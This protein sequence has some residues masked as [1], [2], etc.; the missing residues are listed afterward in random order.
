MEDEYD[1]VPESGFLKPT[2]QVTPNDV[3]EIFR[4]VCLEYVIV[5]SICEMTQFLEGLQT[6]DVATLIKQHPSIM[7]QVF[8]SNTLPVTARDLTNLLV[9]V[10]SP[11]GSN[12]REEEEAIMLNWNYYLQ[13][14]QGKVVVHTLVFVL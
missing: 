8:T 12:A 5:R 6:L 4:S 11:V 7:R 14:I 10:Y 1:F 2:V 13:D 3:P 9:P